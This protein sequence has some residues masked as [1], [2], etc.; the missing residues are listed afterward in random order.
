[1][2]AHSFSTPFF[3]ARAYH[4]DASTPRCVVVVSKKVAGTA[5]ARNRIRRRLYDALGAHL[6]RLPRGTALILY[7]KKEALDAPFRELQNAVEKMKFS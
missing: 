6:A 3:S 4:T 7:A 1:M 5:V 2:S